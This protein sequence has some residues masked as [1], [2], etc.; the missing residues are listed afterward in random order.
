M[1]RTAITLLALVACA[2]PAASQDAGAGQSAEGEKPASNSADGPQ[3]IGRRIFEALNRHRKDNGVPAALLSPKCFIALHDQVQF[4]VAK[5]YRGGSVKKKK[6]AK[7]GKR[8]RDRHGWSLSML[9]N[10]SSGREGGMV[11]EEI[12]KILQADP[13]IRSLLRKDLNVGAAAAAKV[14]NSD[15]YVIVVGLMRMP[16]SKTKN[17]AKVAAAEKAWAKADE[18]KRTS[19]MKG[20]AAMKDGDALLMLTNGL[21]DASA[22]V[23]KQATKGC[24]KLRNCWPVPVLLQRFD[25][26][27]DPKI[28]TS[29]RKALEAISGKKDY[30]DDIRKWRVWWEIEATAFRRKR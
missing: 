1:F 17:L 6:Y 3:A 25:A 22:A 30:K 19:I 13:N 26:E 24:A 21:S 18:K 16:K 15:Q 14:P 28:K 7:L 20:M 5:G 12:I 23:R 27:K 2:L 8:T 10:Y 11:P 4:L 9:D 29:V